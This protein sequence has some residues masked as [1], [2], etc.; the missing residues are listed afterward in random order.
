MVD[1]TFLDGKKLEDLKP[2][3]VS[4]C[5]NLIELTKDEKLSI[6]DLLKTGKTFGEIKRNLNGLLK[7]TV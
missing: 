1:K 2:S 6:V 4:S 3:K 7:R 5:S